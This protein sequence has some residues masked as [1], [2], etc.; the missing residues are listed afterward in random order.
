MGKK[1]KSSSLKSNWWGKAGEAF[2]TGILQAAG[3]V[4]GRRL[5]D[6]VWKT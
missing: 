3:G 5:I 1:K 2:L 4:V 6:R